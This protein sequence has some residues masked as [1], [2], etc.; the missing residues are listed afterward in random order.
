MITIHKKYVIDDQGNPKEVII[1][2]EDFQMIEEL[3]GLDLDQEAIE[4]I[5]Q[6]RQ[7]REEGNKEAYEEDTADVNHIGPRGNIYR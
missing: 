2:F 7:D 1:P 6:A 3:L 4:D 5:R